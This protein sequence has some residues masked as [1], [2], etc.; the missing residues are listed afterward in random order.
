MANTPGLLTA[1]T[2]SAGVNTAFTAPSGTAIVINHMVI[3]ANISATAEPVT[4]HVL[5]GPTAVARQWLPQ[6]AIGEAGGMQFNGAMM[7]EAASHGV[8]VSA[9]TG[10]AL[11]CIIV[12][13]EVT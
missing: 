8:I 11:D 7:L 12:G 1:F 6:T 5:A 10:S 3:N 9:S 2:L 4:A 13:L